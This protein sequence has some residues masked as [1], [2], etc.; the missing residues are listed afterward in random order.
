MT[1]SICSQFSPPIRMLISWKLFQVFRWIIFDIVMNLRNILLCIPDHQFQKE[2]FHLIIYNYVNL[3]I[4]V[5]QFI[6]KS[7]AN[8]SANNKH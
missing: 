7:V 8:A 1:D 6:D 2:R 5:H 4:C 3:L